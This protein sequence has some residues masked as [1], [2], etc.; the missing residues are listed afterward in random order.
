[1]VE[2]YGG[3]YGRKQGLVSTEL[4]AQGVR[5]K[6]S[7]P[8]TTWKSAM[9]KQKVLE[10]ENHTFH[11]G[12]LKHVSK[13]KK[14]ANAIANHIQR[15]YKGGADILKAIKKLSLPTLQVPGYPKAKTVETVVGPGDI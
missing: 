14:M 12:N 13:Y 3:A 2:M 8:Q 6:T 4:E 9:P 7:S 11:I 5:P 15:E 1:M 10:L